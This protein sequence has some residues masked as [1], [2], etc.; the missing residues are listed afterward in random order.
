MRFDRSPD[1]VRLYAGAVRRWPRVSPTRPAAH[2][3]SGWRGVNATS[4]MLEAIVVRRPAQT[5]EQME[6]RA[7][8]ADETSLFIPACE[9]HPLRDKGILHRV[10]SGGRGFNRVT[11]WPSPKP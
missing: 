9:V 4:R 5:S 7:L 10:A 6:H 3:R 2:A 1:T 11:S 8:A